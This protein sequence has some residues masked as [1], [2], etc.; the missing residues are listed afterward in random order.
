MDSPQTN[1]K[2]NQKFDWSKFDQTAQE[3]QSGY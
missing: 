2:F 1:P 3:E